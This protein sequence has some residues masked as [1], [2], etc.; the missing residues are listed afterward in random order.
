MNRFE[1][2]IGKRGEEME[3]VLLKTQES[4]ETQVNGTG[5]IRDFVNSPLASWR[6]LIQERKVINDMKYLETRWCPR[7]QEPNWPLPGSGVLP[8]GQRGGAPWA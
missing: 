7:P 1:E 6:W 2:E 8:W 5:G 3:A 4:E